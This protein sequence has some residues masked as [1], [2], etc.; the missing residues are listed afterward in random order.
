MKNAIIKSKSNIYLRLLFSI[1]TVLS[2]IGA[3]QAATFTVINTNDS[4]TGSL[5]QAIL[6]ANANAGADDIVFNI[7]GGGVQSIRPTTAL[8][9]LVGPVTLDGYTQPGA[10]P[11]T[12]AVG[13]DAVLLV[14][15]DGSL[16]TGSVIGL[17]LGGTGAVVRGIIINRFAEGIRTLESSSGQIIAG[18]VIG[19]DATGTVAF[20]N[21]VGIYAFRT[22]NTRIGGTAPADRNLISGNG[23]EGILLLQGDGSHLVQ[24]NYIGTNAAGTAAL[25]N[26][27]DGIGVGANN[28]T[29]GGAAAGAGNVISGNNAVGMQ[30]SDGFHRTVQGNLIG[31]NATGTAA[32]ANRSNGLNG[33]GTNLTIGGTANGAGNVISGNG[34]NGMHLTDARGAIIQGNLVGVAL[35]GTAPLGNT[36][37]GI[38]IG[39]TAGGFFGGGP[40]LVGGTTAGAGNI[41]ANNGNYGITVVCCE[42]RPSTISG[43]SIYANGNLGI[44]LNLD[45]VTLNDQ[46]DTDVGANGLQNYPVLASA[47]SSGGSTT[48]QGTLN[49]NPSTNF[50]V[51]FFSNS[52]CDASGNGEGQSFLGSINVTTDT[53]GDAPINA[54]FP[55][56]INSGFITSTATRLDSPT[57]PTDTSEFS[58]CVQVLPLTA[59]SVSIGGRVTTARGR[60]VAGAR[61]SLTDASGETRA[62]VT[63]IFGYYHLTD[64]RAGET[65]VLSVSHKRYQ[66][67]PQVIFVAGETGDFNFTTSP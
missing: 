49:S 53:T 9:D 22:I 44:D 3:V 43:N 11:N 33:N 47:S 58:A 29:I 32:V 64:V 16:A 10:S 2:L 50:T 23:R 45:G 24:G 15:I 18:N 14:E 20:G 8:P 59:A 34:V 27:T 5:R 28:V 62:T 31:T 4:G 65:Y 1:L 56:S 7:P 26:G 41:I 54:I 40:T 67:P 36:R 46:G 51:E 60:S 66:F 35:D 17:Q 61:V 30:I 57:N 48:I 25:G 19:T 55:I 12:L 13:N 52:V 38:I 21:G 63:N 37:S 42:G 39:F 6:D